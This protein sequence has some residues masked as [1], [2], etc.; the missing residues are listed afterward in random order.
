MALKI[1]KPYYYVGVQTG[2]FQ[3]GDYHMTLVTHMENYPHHIWEAKNSEKP[4]RLTK[5][6]AEELVVCMALNG[7]FACVVTCMDE[8]TGQPFI[9][10]KEK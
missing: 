2:D 6:M 5:Q 3:K 1:N 7:R 4:I 8:L 9:N 10:H